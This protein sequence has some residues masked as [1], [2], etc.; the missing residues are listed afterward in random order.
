MNPEYRPYHPKWCR[1]KVPIFWWLW[2]WAYVKFICRALT[3]VLVAYSAVMLLV[4][5]VA[6]D[7]GE[8]AYLSFVDWRSRPA[9]VVFHV[10][11]LM[12]VLFHTIT[13]LNLAPMAIVAKVGGRRVPNVAVLLGHYAAW[14]VCS[15]VVV[16]A[17]IWR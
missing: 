12:G 5:V 10:G 3:S 15:T 14:V 1:T 9:V 4:L 16:W 13:W 7:R 6:V 11:V 17:L 2:E 8:A